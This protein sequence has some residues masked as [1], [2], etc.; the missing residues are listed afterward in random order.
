[1]LFIQRYGIF[2]VDADLLDMG[3]NAEHGLA[4]L[5]FKEVERRCQQAHIAAEFI[6]YKPFDKRTLLLVEQFK[7]PDK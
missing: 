3:Y 6:D 7:R 4:R 1:M 2:F 5:F